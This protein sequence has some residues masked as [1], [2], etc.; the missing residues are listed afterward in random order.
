MSIGFRDHEG[1]HRAA[2]G[3]AIG[4]VAAGLGAGVAGVGVEG[5]LFAG[6]AGATLGAGWADREG[7]RS[8]FAARVVLLAMAAGA[9]LAGRSIGGGHV[10]VL[11]LAAVVGLAVNLGVTGWRAV[12]AVLVGGG[13]A[14]LGG[15]AAGQVMIARETASL[16]HALEVA[17]AATAMS[18]VCVA[19]LLPRHL[20]LVTDPVRAAARSLPEGLEPEVRSLLARGTAVWE[21]VSPRLDDEGRALLRDGVLKLHTLA[22]RWSNVDAPA[23]DAAVL[24]KRAEELDARIAAAG[25]DVAREQYR[26][27]RAAVEDQRRYVDEIQKSRER[28]VARLHACVTTLEKFRLAAAHL[29]SQHASRDAV[30]ARG[31]TKLLAEVSAD[32]DACGAAIAELDGRAHAAA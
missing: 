17:L 4:G 24:T 7:G 19:A 26:E 18:V 29:D 27:A 3:M 25:D 5:A 8:R 20:M 11:A 31:A 15:F 22:T 12:A 14:Y 30:E 23:E 1:F 21:Q 9:F 32:L 16:P 13:V 2:A 28:V 6:A 10:G